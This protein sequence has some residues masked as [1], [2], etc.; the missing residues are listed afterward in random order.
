MSG[1]RDKMSRFMSGRYGIDDM[2]RAINILVMILFA[3]SLFGRLFGPLYWAFYIGIIFLIYNYFR[4]FSRN[5]AKRSAENAWFCRVFKKGRS[6]YGRYNGYGNSYQS[7]GNNYQGYMTNEE[8]KAADRKTH[9][10]FKCPNCSQK[11]RV[12]KHRGRICIKCPT[13]R[14]EFIKKT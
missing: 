9:R 10:I 12:P 6:T 4:M 11:I 14:I 8:K 3:V 7:Y 1:F 2:S 13:C 5:Y